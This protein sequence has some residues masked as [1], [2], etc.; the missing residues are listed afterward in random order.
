MNIITHP[1]RFFRE[2]LSGEVSLWLPA[3]AVLAAAVAQVVFINLFLS[4]IDRLVPYPGFLGPAM[5]AAHAAIFITVCVAWLLLAAYFWIFTPGHAGNSQQ[6]FFRRALAVPGYGRVPVVAG[7]IILSVL[8]VVVWPMAGI[9]PA[10][11][12]KYHEYLDAE[13]DMTAHLNPKNPSEMQKAHELLPHVV[14][15]Q[16][17]A[18]EEAV[19]GYNQIIDEIQQNPVMTAFFAAAKGLLVLSA[20]WGGLIMAFGLKH[21]AGVSMKT[22][23]VLVALPVGLEI[24]LIIMSGPGP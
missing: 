14:S 7:Y 20:L 23:A 10:P 24:L 6:G 22:S 21:A 5:P 11:G 3:A 4:S 1:D 19:A 9:A 12:E 8:F 18:R 2:R 16:H 17:E 15:L 13:A